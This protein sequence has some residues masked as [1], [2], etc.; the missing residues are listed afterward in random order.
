M[1]SIQRLFGFDRA[2]SWQRLGSGQV[3]IQRL[4]GFDDIHN[5]LLVCL[6]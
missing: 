3:S 5:L 6:D 1:V 4:F 2:A